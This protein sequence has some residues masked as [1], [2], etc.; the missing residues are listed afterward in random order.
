[1]PGVVAVLTADEAKDTIPPFPPN[2]GPKQPPRY[3]IARDKVRTVGEAV[4]VALAEDRYL[5]YDAA[6]AVA[7]EYEPLPA[8]V[9]PEAAMTPDAPQ[10]WEDFP[11]NVLFRDMTFGTGDVEAAFAQA[12]VVIRQRMTCT[13]LAPC[14]I[15]PRGVVAT[16]DP[17]QGQLTVWST[18]QAPH[19]MRWVLARLT[20]LPA[21][22]IRVIAPEW[23]AASA[24]RATRT[25]GRPWP[26]C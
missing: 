2:P 18:T 5:A 4:A 3:L 23:A 13:R 21:S 16:Y 19:R 1:M 15:E 20:G 12:D 9:D 6:E 7:V 8:V 14:A 26:A 25:M 24:P 11:G 22:R 10:L 17:W